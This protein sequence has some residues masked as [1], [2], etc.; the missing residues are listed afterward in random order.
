MKLKS[1]HGSD[2]EYQVL[3]HVPKVGVP[4]AHG[5]TSHTPNGTDPGS[6]PKPMPYPL[7]RMLP[8]WGT[9]GQ[10]WTLSS[11]NGLS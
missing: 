3:N 11:C 2:A 9:R 7:G 6:E 8:R 5:G 4:S 1:Y 10:R